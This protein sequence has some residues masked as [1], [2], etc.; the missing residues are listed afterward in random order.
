MKRGLREERQRL[1]K[2]PGLALPGAPSFAGQSMNM[3]AKVRVIS[4]GQEKQNGPAHV[5][6]AAFIQF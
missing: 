1:R 4:N 3:P 2:A 5:R 6:R